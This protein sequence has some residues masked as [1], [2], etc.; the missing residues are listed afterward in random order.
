MWRQRESDRQLQAGF[1][2]AGIAAIAGGYWASFQPSIYA[3]SN[4]WTSSPNVRESLPCD[5]Y[6]VTPRVR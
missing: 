6:T 2:L 1:L 3:V 5:P 4:F